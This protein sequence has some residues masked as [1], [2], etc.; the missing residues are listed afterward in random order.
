MTNNIIDQLLFLQDVLNIQVPCVNDYLKDVLLKDFFLRYCYEV[1]YAAPSTPVCFSESWHESQPLIQLRTS[2]FLLSSVLNAMKEI[3]FAPPQR[4]F[5]APRPPERPALPLLPRGRPPR[6][7][8]SPASPGRCAARR[9]PPL[10]VG[11]ARRANRSIN[12]SPSSQGAPAE[13]IALI[14]VT[15]GVWRGCEAKASPSPSLPAGEASGE[16]G[17]DAS[18]RGDERPDGRV[19]ETS[20]GS[21]GRESNGSL[22]RESNDSLNSKPN[23]SLNSEPKEGLKEASNG[24]LDKESNQSNQSLVELKAE[25]SQSQTLQSSEESS[26]KLPSC[27]ANP[28]STQNETPNDETSQKEK[29]EAKVS[30]VL[31]PF[32]SEV[33]QRTSDS[34]DSDDDVVLL[35]DSDREDDL[36][37]GTADPLASTD[38][39][40]DKDL[41]AA[42]ARNATILR[43]IQHRHNRSY[44]T[45]P[46]SSVSPVSPVSPTCRFPRPRRLR[47]RHRSPSLPAAPG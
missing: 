25:S 24:S 30:A 45:F 33:L 9:A 47:P 39:R 16:A 27:E 14:T 31:S 23:D 7:D 20:D 11:S 22:G 8:A 18:G 40:G 2:L 36:P 37:R 13:R 10:R 6:R 4:S 43:S 3:S 5:T 32:S 26:L 21:L 42:A 15:V 17:K 44:D 38:S 19:K 35:V 1:I 34:S 28:G 46:T 12:L 41:Q 29:P